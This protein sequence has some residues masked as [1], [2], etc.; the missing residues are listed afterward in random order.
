VV[1][2]FESKAIRDVC[3]QKAVADAQLGVAA[4]EQLRHRLGDIDAAS[5]MRDLIAGNPRIVDSKGCEYLLIDLSEGY[6]LVLKANHSQCPLTPD[7]RIDWSLVNRVKLVQIA[8]KI[9]GD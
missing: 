8:T 9:D 4:A 1:L 5:S 3:E 2:A 7:N 6:E